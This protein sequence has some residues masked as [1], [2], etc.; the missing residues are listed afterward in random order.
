MVWD[1][2]DLMSGIT[3][4]QAI[5]IAAKYQAISRKDIVKFIPPTPG[6]SPVKSFKVLL[7]IYTQPDL[8]AAAIKRL[9]NSQ[10]SSTDLSISHLLNCG[11]IE[12]KN[13]SYW[14]R[15]IHA[16]RILTVYVASAAGKKTIVSLFEG[17]YRENIEVNHKIAS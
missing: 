7:T 13:K 5:Q 11:L 16:W 6:T 4:Q 12:P 1:N 15:A 17:I 3:I 14:V 9:Y 2:F 10:S 8:T